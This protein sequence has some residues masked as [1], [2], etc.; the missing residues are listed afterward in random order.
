MVSKQQRF[1]KRKNYPTECDATLLKQYIHLLLGFGN[2]RKSDI[3][4]RINAYATIIMIAAAPAAAVVVANAAAPAARAAPAAPAAAPAAA[5][6]AS[7][8]ARLPAPSTGPPETRCDVMFDV[9]KPKQSRIG[10][11][12]LSSHWLSQKIT[13]YILSFNKKIPFRPPYQ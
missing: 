3:R 2:S 5:S 7:A 6:A 11:R 8:A 4:E 1:K 9:T 10:R 12:M 13:C